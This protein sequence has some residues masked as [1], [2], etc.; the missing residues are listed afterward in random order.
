MP[1]SQE[2]SALPDTRTDPGS[3]IRRWCVR[4]DYLRSQAL[5]DRHIGIVLTIRETGQITNSGIQN[6][7]GVS[8]RQASEDL[9]ILEARNL[10]ERKG[11]TERG[12]RYVL[13]GAEGAV[14]GQ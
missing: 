4:R 12:T 13:K 14:K 11:T 5:N 6:V 8:K 3:R 7:S 1:S 10:I 9:A 2:E